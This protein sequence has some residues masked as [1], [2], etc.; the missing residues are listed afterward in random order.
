[1]ERSIESRNYGAHSLKMFVYLCTTNPHRRV[2]S[3]EPGW[4]LDRVLHQELPQ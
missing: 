4:V 2:I 3:P 1:M